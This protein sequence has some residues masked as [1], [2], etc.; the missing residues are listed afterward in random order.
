MNSKSTLCACAA[1]LPL[2]LCN[3]AIAQGTAFS[4]QGRLS[5]GTAAATGIYD[6][7]FAVHDASTNGNAAAGPVIQ[8]AVDVRNGLFSVTLD[9]GPAVFTGSNRWLEISVRT[10]G[11]STFTT[12]TP[13]QPLLPTPYAI[14]AANLSGTLG[15]TQLNG[16]LPSSALAGEYSAI[17]NFNNE[18]NHY[19]G[20]GTALKFGGFGY[21]ALPC[22]WNLNGNAG[23]VGQNFIGTT[24]NTPLEFRVNGRR[25]LRLEPTT[26]SPNL[27]GGFE[28]NSV[29]G[30]GVGNTIGGGGSVHVLNDLWRGRQQ[31]LRGSVCHNR[32]GLLQHR[33]DGQRLPFTRAVRHDRGWF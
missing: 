20:D 26:N 3:S 8:N 4:Y 17:L 21:C 15:A 1:L 31:D 12:L 14:T 9:F 29:D 2:L 23:T 19:A 10:N 27:I 28:G 32:R 11:D 13:R 33:C 30:G 6:L 5:D 7:R 25:A 18:S 22:Y 16:V 24:D